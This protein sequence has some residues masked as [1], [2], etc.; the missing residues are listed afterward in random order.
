MVQHKMKKKVTLPS[1][2]KQKKK[3]KSTKQGP[4]K[5]HQ[6]TIAPKKPSAVQQA[7]IDTEITR[8]INEKNEQLLKSR[9]DKDVGRGYW[10]ITI[11]I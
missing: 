6:L 9:A 8:T 5:G 1:G 4:K 7:K 10:G 2:V 3:M 11:M